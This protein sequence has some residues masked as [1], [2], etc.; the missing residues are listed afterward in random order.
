MDEAFP[1]APLTGRSRDSSWL[2]SPQPRP[3][4]IV[5]TTMASSLRFSIS[6]RAS[7][8][9][10]MGPPSTRQHCERACVSTETACH[11]RTA[12]RAAGLTVL[13]AH[14]AG[15]RGLVPFRLL[16]RG[17]NAIDVAVGFDEVV[18]DP[19]G[20]EDRLGEPGG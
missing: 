10:I 13:S 1:I 14:Q 17:R 12:R 19:P 16:E 9:S 7:F 18:V 2:I 11:R 4:V 15:N 6:A 5:G 8:M 20:V 3:P